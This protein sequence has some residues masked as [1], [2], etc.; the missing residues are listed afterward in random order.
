[1][2]FW[3]VDYHYRSKV[4]RGDRVFSA[5]LTSRLVHDMIQIL[6]ALNEIYYVG[7]GQ[8]LDFVRKFRIVPPGFPEKVEEVLYPPAG[9][10]RLDVQY[11]MLGALIDEVVQ[12]A[13]KIEQS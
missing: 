4:E 5:A 6:F 8:N 11:R 2:R 7:D 13:E 1:M 9:D 10:N 12:L 3:R